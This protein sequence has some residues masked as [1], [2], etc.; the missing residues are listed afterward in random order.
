VI[1]MIDGNPDSEL[2]WPRRSAPAKSPIGARCH[3]RT[4]ALRRPVR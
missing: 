2:H 1:K 3:D 4:P